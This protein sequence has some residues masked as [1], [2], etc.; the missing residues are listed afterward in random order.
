MTDKWQSKNSLARQI[1]EYH[2]KQGERTVVEIRGDANA[3]SPEIET[4][5]SL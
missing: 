4:L 1:Q 5:N 2:N 3:G